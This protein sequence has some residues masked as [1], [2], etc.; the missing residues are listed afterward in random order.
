MI[1]GLDTQGSVFLT[2]VQANSNSKIMEIYLHE[3]VAKLD[4]ERPG[5]RKNTCLLW[6]NAPYH[7][8]PATL[9]VLEKLK[10]PVL[11]TGPHSYDASPCELFFAHFKKADINPNRLAT[12]KANF[13][14]VVKM[15]VLRAREIPRVNRVLFWRHCLIHIYRYLSF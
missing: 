11:F 6:D 12:G 13:R 7:S 4:D 3:L 9:G 8:S 1:V 14:N 2:L 10:I 5:W 15:T